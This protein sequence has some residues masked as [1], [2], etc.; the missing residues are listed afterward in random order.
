MRAISEKH[1]FDMISLEQTLY[2][3]CHEL[4]SGAR[5]VTDYFTEDCLFVVG[6][7]AWHGHDGLREHY[8]AD[9]Q[10]VKT[11][12][13]DGRRTVRHALLNQRIRVHGDGKATVDLIF[14]NFSA[15]G[16]PPF[17]RSSAP[18]VVADTRLE[19]LRDAAGHWRIHEFHATPQYFGDDPYLNTVLLQM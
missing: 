9:A 5:R 17:V 10:A 12:Y 16:A 8:A 1:L 6:G 3:Y 11:Y 18:T 19:C 4:D 13:Q 2:D 7:T 15:G 14:L